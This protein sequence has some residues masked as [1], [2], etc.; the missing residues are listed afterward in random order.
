MEEEEEA[1]T[2]VD[3]ATAIAADRL[4]AEDITTLTRAAQLRKDYT[5]LLAPVCLNAVRIRSQTKQE[6][7]GRN[8][9]NTS[10]QITA[11]I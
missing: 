10:A 2:A 5:M 4:E 3:T 11:K 9:C 6:H 1:R 7:H 8:S